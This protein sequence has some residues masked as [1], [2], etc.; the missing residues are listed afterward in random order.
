MTP[1]NRDH[2]LVLGASLAGLLAATVLAEEYQRVTVVERDPLP[3]GVDQH[4]RGVPHGHH[5]HGL[6]ARGQLVMEELLPG[7]T[8]ELVRQGA[9]T[10]DVLANVRWILQGRKLCQVPTGLPVISASRPLIEGT[11]RARV[12]AIPTITIVDGCDIVG[13]TASADGL[14]VAGARIVRRSGEIT[15]NADLVV[16][17]TG[18]GSRTPL[19]LS[20]L[21]YEQPVEDRVTVGLGYAS[22]LYRLPPEALDG[23]VAVVT[24]RY[25]GTSRNAI[26]QAIE[27]GRCLVTL[28]GILGDHPP[29]DD[30]GFVGYMKTLPAPDTHEIVG[31]AEPLTAP[32]P[33][34]FPASVRRRYESLERFPAG[35]L[36]T[37]DAVCSFN[38]VYA[39]G[40]TVSALD[41]LALRDE[42]RHG[43][44]PQAYRFFRSVARNLR[45]PW[46]VTVGGDLAEPR[47]EGRRTRK[48]RVIGSYVARLQRAAADDPALSTAFVRVSG[49]IDPPPRLM[50]PDRVARVLLHGLHRRSTQAVTTGEEPVK[51][52]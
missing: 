24:A 8:D 4:R 23:D 20:E 12:R 18:R 25:P 13:L 37:G 1:S 31:D 3:S 41:A 42:L 50:R 14:R 43:G 48:M 6:L 39:Q 26:L 9:R 28:A 38:P 7:L 32:V 36:V 49:L 16:D 19:W 52:W 17:A 22:R 34:R 11:V 15:L 33:F 27:G 47:V 35:L 2:A 30:D 10:G 46:N 21:G 29:L 51:I 5:A 40:M 44:E 45:A